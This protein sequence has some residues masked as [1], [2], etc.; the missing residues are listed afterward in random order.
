VPVFFGWIPVGHGGTFQEPDGGD[1]ARV[2]ARWLDWQ[3][4][5]DADASWDFAGPD[6]RLCRD[7]RWTVEQKQLPSPMGPRSG[8][9][10]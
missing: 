8:G 10:R 2:S 1:W 4:N 9:P 5:T 3:L 6:C 7:P